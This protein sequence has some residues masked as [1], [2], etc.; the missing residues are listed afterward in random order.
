MDADNWLEDT[1][2]SYD[3][4]AVSY[5]D[6]LRE[7]LGERPYLRAALA[8]LA[9]LVRDA[10]AGRWPTWAAGRGTSPPTCTSWASTPS[11]STSPRR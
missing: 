5:A 3:T 8:L 9:D 6:R 11:A 1:R 4:V 7:A 10:G 2:A